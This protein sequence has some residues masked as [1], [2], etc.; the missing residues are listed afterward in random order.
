[1]KQIIKTNLRV[2]QPLYPIVGLNETEANTVAAL[3]D[4]TQF[5]AEM[6]MSESAMIDFREAIHVA[7]ILVV[8]ECLIRRGCKV[9]P[10]QYKPHWVKVERL[11]GI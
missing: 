10:L 1:M 11:L 5:A 6:G 9:W 7:S 4:A 3:R 2:K 8:R